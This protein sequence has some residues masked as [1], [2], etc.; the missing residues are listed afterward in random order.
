MSTYYDN[1]SEPFYNIELMASIMENIMEEM[2]T[3]E[4]DNA[5]QFTIPYQA[6]FMVLMNQNIDLYENLRL[7]IEDHGQHFLD[8]LS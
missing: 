8:N 6:S 1:D 5:P 2:A 7:F 3:V 4:G